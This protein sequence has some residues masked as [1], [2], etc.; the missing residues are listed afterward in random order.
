M[1]NE[2]FIAALDNSPTYSRS[3]QDLDNII[4]ILGEDNHERQQHTYGNEE[5]TGLDAAESGFAA[6]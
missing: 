5:E 6:D 3:Q 1:M 2:E 4:K